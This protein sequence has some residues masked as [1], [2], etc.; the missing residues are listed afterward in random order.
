MVIYWIFKVGDCRLVDWRLGLAFMLLYHY[1]R[2]EIYFL[3]EE[4]NLL[5]S[6]DYLQDL[7]LISNHWL[8]NLSLC[9][10][11]LRPALSTHT[12]AGLIHK[13]GIRCNR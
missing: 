7:K 5:D 10:R 9:G 6:E 12:P 13:A 3:N 1:K 4:K 8:T 2:N 11:C